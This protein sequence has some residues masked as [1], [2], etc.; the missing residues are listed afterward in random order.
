MAQYSKVR[1]KNFRL[2]ER[3]RSEELRTGDIEHSLKVYHR[4][5]QLNHVW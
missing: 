4:R 5:H 2:T 1:D 3:L